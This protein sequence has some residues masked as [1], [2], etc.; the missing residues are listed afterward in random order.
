MA[1][2][3]SEIQWFRSALQSQTTPAQNG[4]RFTETEIVSN[5][6]NNIFPDVS[7]AQ[8]AA[9]VEHWKKTFIGVRNADDLPLVDPK[10]SIESG[11]PGD[12]YVL[13]YAGTQTDTEATRSGRPYGY[14]VLAAGA[15]AAAESI[16]VTVESADYDGMSPNPFQVGDLIR[17]D[18]RST[19]LSETGD[20]EYRE[21]ESIS[22]T[23]ATA[24][25]G[26]TDGLEHT[27]LSGV[28]VAAV[29][30][31]GDIIGGVTSKSVTGGVTYDDTTYPI[32]VPSIGG[33]Y[34]AWTITVTNAATGALRVTG[35]TLGVVGNG[36]QGVNL[37]P[38]NPNGGDY[39]E[40]DADGWGGTAVTG[41]TLLFT[42]VP[43]ATPVW[44]HR[45]VPAGAAAISAD[46]VSLC[47]EG[48]SAP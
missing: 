22:Y 2:E 34:Q 15:S 26:L 5:V 12:S 7:S 41:D 35:D 45:V 25:I 20:Y 14:G 42:T 47:I 10:I 18:A 32:T 38:A 13:I 9:G 19:V 11:T 16:S 30:E 27:Y 8:R 28:K 29:L 4:G 3:T 24:T 46:P 33:V 31:P 39:F 23:G 44:Y 17:I 40:L 6:K 1:I 37:S 21:I 36:S 43:A 48:E